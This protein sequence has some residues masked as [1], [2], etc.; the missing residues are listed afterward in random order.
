MDAQAIVQLIS[1]VGFPITMC[2]AMGWFVVDQTNK[3]REEVS[4][5]NE[6]HTTIMLAY[7]DEIKD[8]INNNTVVM[9]R[10]CTT[11]ET[12][13]TKTTKK[14]NKGEEEKENEA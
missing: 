8:A 9:E 10:L 12:K 4:K 14:S 13:N 2:V 3:H 1:T 11:M 7:K 5:L 6:Q